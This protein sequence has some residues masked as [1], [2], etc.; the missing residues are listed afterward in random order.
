MSLFVHVSRPTFWEGV[1]VANGD[2]LTIF[3]LSSQ[4]SKLNVFR[5]GDPSW[6]FS[7]IRVS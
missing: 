5:V 6:D 1:S 3:L 4:N 7:L 2:H